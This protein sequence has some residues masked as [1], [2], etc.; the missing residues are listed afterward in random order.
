MK[1]CI[2]FCSLFALICLVATAQS[3][4]LK[5]QRILTDPAKGASIEYGTPGTALLT[6][7]QEGLYSPATAGTNWHVSDAA[8]IDSWA[9]VS[10]KV[11]KTAAGWTLN[12]QRLSVYG[13]TNVPVWEVPLTIQ[14]TEES[15]DM[16]EDGSRMAN[17]YSHSIQVYDPASS[18]ALW[19]TTITRSV[20]GIRIPGDGLHVFV[21]SVNLPAGDSSF[22]SCYTVGQSTPVWTKSYPG[23]Y[24]SLVINKSATRVL[25]GVYGGGYT[26]IHVL[27]GSDG[28]FIFDAPTSDQYPPSISDDG[29]YIV[30]GNFSGFVY[31]Y[32]YDDALTTYTQ[33]W[34]H[35]VNGTNSWVCGMAISADG[36]TIAV[37]TLVFLTAGY[38]GE[39]YVFDN[40]SPDPLW[41]YPGMGDMVQCVDISGDGSIIAAG[42]WGP[43]DNSG[44]DFY[45]F[46]KQSSTPYFTL[47]T[48]GSLFCLDLSDDGKVCVTGG[49][50][51]HARAF[52][53][54]GNLYNINSSP[55][56]GTLTGHAV[57][58]GS[59][60]QAGVKAEIVGLPTYYGFTDDLS[61]YTV[62]Y[63]PAGTY[64][65]RYSAVGYVTQV[66]TGVVISDDQTTVRDVTLLP[67]GDPPLNLS[68]TQGAFSY[69]RL[70]WDASPAPD[71]TG[72]N[73]YRKIYDFSDYPSTP[74]G[75]V[76]AGTLTF[77]DN[78]ALPLTHYYYAVTA[79]ISDTLQSPYS[80]DAI[81]WTASGF[82]T[83]EISAY[84]GTTPVI[85]G[86]IS[87]GEWNDAFRVDL[88]DFL[89]IYDNAPD[90]VASVIGYFKVNAA[91]S[92]LYVAVEN[93]DDAILNDHDEI[94][95]YVDDNNDGVYPPPSDNSEG[96]YWAVHY[97]TGDL[98]RYRP[99]YN[100]GGVG[101]TVLVPNAQ[102]K[103]SGAS[104]H[105]VY[106]FVIP[107]G[108]DST[109]QINFNNLN[110]SGIFIFALDDPSA[111]N[112]WWPCTNPSIFSPADYGTITFGA[113][114]EVP[115]P[116]NNLQL[117]NP[118]AQNIMLQWEQPNINDFDHFNIYE[119][120][121][122]GA[123]N[124]LDHTFGVQYFLTVANGNYQFYVTTIDQTGHESVPS[125][126]VSA[127]VTV[128]VP[129]LTD[130]L[131]M[132]KFGP[133]P[134]TDQLSIDLRT[135]KQTFLQIRICDLSGK[136]IC[137][138]ENSQVD[139]GDHHYLWNGKNPEGDN[140]PSGFYTLGVRTS[141]GTN[142]SC[143]LVK[144][145]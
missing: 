87:P 58:S 51:V 135:E 1:K 9:K 137:T 22:V 71:V 31:L 96:N 93:F 55:G 77:D 104:G 101:T 45:L 108:I 66:V 119:A 16:N 114:D 4:P 43:F 60:A 64:S 103:V 131:A 49:K 79:K 11:Q 62:G 69:V 97:A 36:S 94:A 90:P 37:G 144:I 111:F 33:K 57:K 18:T 54:G 42:G 127:D 5:N 121:N 2:L 128:G 116:P 76:G 50:G 110:Q 99:L 21:A 106:E 35:K 86:I 41:I 72:Y 136:V 65:V 85:D 132:F 82:V 10:S 68:A 6:G 122:G 17:G 28:A 8:A 102:V 15:V 133:N 20:S 145:R 98:I 13:T 26:L 46:R 12:N 89:G 38:D 84:S 70:S 134:F 123:F 48:P 95:L 40:N 7:R 3:V 39:L 44:P 63:I 47:N 27:N 75:T 83:S 67:V 25:L 130:D 78:T 142:H 138:L 80:N 105:V 107:L 29:K 19:S 81:G 61:V 30:N 100:N 88:S 92:S 129:G 56:G 53:S 143:K 139:K 59:A 124:L 140:L 23:S 91:K 118:V 125:N 115:P 112:G 113:T 74:L 109:W 24:A 141:G 32:E 120:V 73:I 126:T 52:G 34:S 14:T 117:F